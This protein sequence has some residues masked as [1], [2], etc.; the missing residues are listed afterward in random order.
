MV[1]ALTAIFP[2]YS[3]TDKSM[4]KGDGLCFGFRSSLCASRW[5]RLSRFPFPSPPPINPR[6]WLL[7]KGAVTG[8]GG[9]GTL[10]TFRSLSALLRLVVLT[11]S[12]AL[13]SQS[14]VPLLR[15][16]GLDGGMRQGG[17]GRRRC[18]SPR[19]PQPWKRGR[20]TEP[21]EGQKARS[22]K[23]EAQCSGCFARS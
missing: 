16:S 11:D 17:P 14:K 12:F 5:F 7:L 18:C 21:A 23:G 19:L 2:P 8:G 15:I 1:T 3:L 4:E 13:R 9:G 10:G 20:R 22:G 6:R